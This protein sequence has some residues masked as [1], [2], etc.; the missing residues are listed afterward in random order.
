MGDAGF[1]IDLHLVFGAHPGSAVDSFAQDVGVPGKLA[2][3]DLVSEG[4]FGTM[5]V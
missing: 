1:L 4:S 5:I 2:I 3:S